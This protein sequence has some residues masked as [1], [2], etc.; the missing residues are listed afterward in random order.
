MRGGLLAAERAAAAKAVDGHPDA[1]PWLWER[2]ADAGPYCS[3]EVCRGQAATSDVLIL[4]VSDELTPATEIEWRAAQENGAVCAILVREGDERDDALDAF[5]RTEGEHVIYK[6]FGTLSELRSLVRDVLRRAHTSAVREAIVRRRRSG[7]PG[8]HSGLLL[9]AG[10]EAAERHYWDGSAKVAAGIISEIEAISGVG[11]DRPDSLDLIA[12]LVHGAAG[13]SRK[14]IAAYQRILQRQTSSKHEMALAHQN[15][16]LEALKAADLPRARELMRRAMELHLDEHDWFGVLQMLL[17][18]GNLAIGEGKLDDAERLADLAEQLIADAGEKLPRQA[19]SILGLRGLVAAHRDRPADAL[20]LFRRAHQQSVRYGD[21]DGEMVSAENIG[22]AYANLGRPAFARRWA[23]RALTIAQQR[24]HAWREEQVQRLL[25]V[26]AFRDGDHATSLHHFGAARALAA[27]M[28]D[29]WRVATLTA[30]IAAIRLAV[31]DPGAEAELDEAAKLLGKHGDD[32]WL[33]RVELNRAILGR[34]RGDR[35]VTVAALERALQHSTGD[36]DTT[37]QVHEEL[38]FVYLE[39][40]RNGRAALTHFRLAV[41]KAAEPAASRA[42]RAATY[43]VHLQDAG[44]LDEALALFDNAVAIADSGRDREVAFHVRNDRGLLLV[45]RGELTEAVDVFV[46]GVMR[47]RRVKNRRLEAQALHNLGETYRRIDE[48]RR[49]ARALRRAVMLAAQTGDEASR[50]GALALLAIT[51]LASGQTDEAEGQA[52]EVLDLARQAGDR[53]DESAALGTLAGVAF[54]R[55]EYATAVDKYRHAAR[56]NRGDPVHHAED[57]CGVMESCAAAGRWSS[58]VRAAQ[59]AID[60]VQAKEL[61]PKAWRSVLRA[62]RW[63]LDRGQVER[64][65]DLVAPACVL[66]HQSPPTRDQTVDNVDD[67]SAH[68][69]ALPEAILTVAFHEKWSNAKTDG[70]WD[71]VLG[72]LGLDDETGSNMRSVIEA[73]RQVAQHADDR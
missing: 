48:Y 26:V 58:T 13:D 25:A 5:L 64:A 44:R 40:P 14:A 46:D 55:G 47:A 36:D 65:A 17:N 33:A 29:T 72:Q 38:A 3:I 6:A 51:S 35:A 9:E 70:L 66:A 34:Q 45:E 71:A 15:L 12:G 21:R 11:D 50:R 10:V 67:D 20:P 16:G 19:A 22:S 61:Q 8:L 68:L 52:S 39:E 37:R 43:A 54:A 1:E 57:L 27:R 2:S 59:R 53:A 23:L 4:I 32:D 56:L 18:L 7:E 42:Y 62:A 60:F 69:G 73:A 30:D 63:F 24:G 31:H 49:S 28:G 41:D